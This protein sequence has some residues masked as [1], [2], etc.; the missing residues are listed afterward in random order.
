MGDVDVGRDAT[1][2]LALTRGSRT[3]MLLTHVCCVG[4]VSEA[5]TIFILV[6]GKARV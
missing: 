6:E 1:F 3:D 4:R 5:S 2:T